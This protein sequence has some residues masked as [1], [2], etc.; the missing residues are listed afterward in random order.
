VVAA[1]GPLGVLKVEGLR[2]TVRL[3]WFGRMF[4]PD[5]LDVMPDQLARAYPIGRIAKKSGR[6]RS[7]TGV[8]FTDLHGHDFYFYPGRAR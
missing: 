6:V 3:R 5:D 1:S 4:G 8:G 7:V 2:L